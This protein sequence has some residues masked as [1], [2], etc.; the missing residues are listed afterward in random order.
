M[1]G[2]TLEITL[3]S[4]TDFIVY[5]P[6]TGWYVLTG[7]ASMLIAGGIAADSWKQQATWQKIGTVFVGVM[8]ASI[9]IA[10]PFAYGFQRTKYVGF[11]HVGTISLEDQKRN[12]LSSIA[13]F[14]KQHEVT[15]AALLMSGVLSASSMLFSENR[16]D[17]SSI[18]GAALI[19]FVALGL[20]YLNFRRANKTLREG[21]GPQFFVSALS[22]GDRLVPALAMRMHW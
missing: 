11:S 17:R 6:H 8:G 20:N 14:N 19:P 7:G 10:T 5:G 16:D 13:S 21:L 18:A 9:I 3:P 2:R 1:S 12:V 15:N 22:E 4:N